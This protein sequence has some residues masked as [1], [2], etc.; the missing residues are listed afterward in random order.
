MTFQ[1]RRF[2]SSH[3]KIRTVLN[4]F[5][6]FVK[7]CGNFVRLNPKLTVSKLRK[8]KK[9]FVFSVFIYSIKWER[10][11]R[12]VHIAV[13]QR[14]LRNNRKCTKKRDARAKLLFC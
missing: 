7:C 8:K 3:K 6:Y 1:L 13:L 2:Y 5:I 4:C 14:R 10:E 11:V 9:M 12:N